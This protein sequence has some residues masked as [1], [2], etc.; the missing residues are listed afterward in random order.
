MC[1]RG[2]IAPCIRRP[3]G[4]SMRLIKDSI[5]GMT[6]GGLVRVMGIFLVRRIRGRCLIRP[7]E[8]WCSFLL[9]VLWVGMECLGGLDSVTLVVALLW[10]LS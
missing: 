9:R 10:V 2:S 7:I 8:W 4:N 1:R 3:G 5:A 6:G